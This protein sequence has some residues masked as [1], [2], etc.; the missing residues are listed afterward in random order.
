V[1][2]P[3]VADDDRLSEIMVLSVSVELEE[4]VREWVAVRLPDTLSVRS[5]VSLWLM[6][7]SDTVTLPVG[8]A[9]ASS[10]VKEALAVHA[11]VAPDIDQDSVAVFDLLVLPTSLDAVHESEVLVSVVDVVDNESVG[12]ERD[13]DTLA[14]GSELDKSV[15]VDADFDELCVRSPL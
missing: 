14:L 4:R 2:E 9:D 12:P 6:D 8:V 10:L 3:N 5:L 7:Q 11:D 1:A 15:D 13:D